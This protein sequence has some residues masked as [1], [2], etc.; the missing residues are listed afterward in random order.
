MAHFI[1]DNSIQLLIPQHRHA[2]SA[3][4]VLVGLE[5]QL[6]QVLAAKELVVCG[7][8]IVVFRA[9]DVESPAGPAFTV[10]F[11]IWSYNARFD[12]G[13]FVQLFEMDY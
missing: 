4:V 13:I 7:A 9:L 6:M 10:A 2:V 12:A 3:L 8:L 1:I 11:G 5:I